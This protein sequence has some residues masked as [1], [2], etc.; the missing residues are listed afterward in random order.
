MVFIDYG[1]G[2]VFFARIVIGIPCS[3]EPPINAT[4]FPFLRKYQRKYR[5]VYKLQPYV[6]CVKVRWHMAKKSHCVSI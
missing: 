4:S 6:Q 2:V 3:S 5:Q 1:L